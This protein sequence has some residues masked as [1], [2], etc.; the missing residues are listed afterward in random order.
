M[1]NYILPVMLLLTSLVQAQSLVP[2]IPA[3]ARLELRSGQFIIDPG[4][5]LRYDAAQPEL[6]RIAGWFSDAVHRISGLR[7]AQQRSGGRSISLKL[8]LNDGLGSEGYR[9][10]V[11]P[12]QVS[13]EASGPAGVFYALQS[14]LQTLPG[15]RTNA[16]MAVPCMSVEDKPRFGWRGLHLD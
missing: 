1:R 11:T 6:R 16:P 15:I 5:T 3:P 13:I 2:L 4:T 12:A 14:V 10:E 9:L 8:K 7:L